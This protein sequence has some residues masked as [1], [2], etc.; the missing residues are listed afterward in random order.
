MGILGT[1]G[2]VF[3]KLRISTVPLL[4]GYVLGPQLE[5]TLRRALM[6]SRGDY[7]VF[8][9]SPISMVLLAITV[10]LLLWALRAKDRKNLGALE[11]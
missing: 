1:V 6:I 7:S 8:V 9:T 5:T 3:A 10:G 11:A 2:Y 4:L